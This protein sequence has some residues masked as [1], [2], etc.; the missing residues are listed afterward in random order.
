[1]YLVYD[2]NKEIEDYVSNEEDAYA[3]IKEFLEDINFKSYYYR[4]NFLDDGTIMVDYGA[5]THFFYIKDV[6][7]NMKI[8]KHSENE[9]EITTVF[10]SEEYKAYY[11]AIT[12]YKDNDSCV[13]FSDKNGVPLIW[14]GVWEL[15]PY[16]HEKTVDAVLNNPILL[17]RLDRWKEYVNDDTEV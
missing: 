10:Y 14:Y 12:N 11:V 17:D 16:N 9:K 3:I 6:G 8:I 15:S 7:E 4:Q 5:H 2:S 1:M 13:Y